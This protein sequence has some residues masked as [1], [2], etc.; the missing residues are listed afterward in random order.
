MHSLRL[1]QASWLLSS[2]A[3]LLF[4]PPTTGA[5]LLEPGDLLAMT[6]SAGDQPRKAGLG[7]GWRGRG[8]ES[9]GGGWEEGGAGHRQLRFNSGAP[10]C[11]IHSVRYSHIG[12]RC[13]RIFAMPSPGLTRAAGR[14]WISRW[15]CILLLSSS[16]ARLPFSTLGSFQDHLEHMVESYL[17]ITSATL[18]DF[19][20]TQRDTRAALQDRMARRVGP[21][22]GVFTMRRIKYP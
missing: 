17:K 9:R 6:G 4:E 22:R 21:N 19:P 18:L 20:A 3:V 10:T 15:C 8:E 2:S 7:D 13:T 5:V 1:I 12:R 14:R 16:L 11:S